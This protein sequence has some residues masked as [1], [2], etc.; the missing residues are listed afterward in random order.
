[1]YE[2]RHSLNFFHKFYIRIFIVVL[3]V[4]LELLD[5]LKYLQAMP[6]NVPSVPVPIE[7][8]RV[9]LLLVNQGNINTL[10]SLK[11]YN[12]LFVDLWA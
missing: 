11:L 6:Y 10:C 12:V 4:H 2:L 8:M 5:M 9:K 1:M 3:L 7:L